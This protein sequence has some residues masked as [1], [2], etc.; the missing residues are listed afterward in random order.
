MP[1]PI[2]TDTPDNQRGLFNPQALL[3]EVSTGAANITVGVPTNA[4]TIWVS[5]TGFPSTPTAKCQGVQTGI[6]Y[7]GVRVPSQGNITANP[8]WVFDVSSAVDQDVTI[9]FSVAP[10]PSW[11]VYADAAPRIVT[12]LT[13][14]VNQQGL[15]YVIPSAPNTNPGDHPPNELQL[16]SGNMT[17]SGVLLGA[18]GANL[19]YRIFALQM[20]GNN[21]GSLGSINN[22]NG[23]PGLCTVLGPVSATVTLPLTGYAL[24]TNTP[25]WANVPAFG[26]Y[27]SAYYTTE[28]V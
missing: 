15:Q 20:M 10:A 28:N 22:G 24:S 18:P 17:A 11:Y 4:E 23:G 21:N 16:G 7:V 27:W 3:A 2:A 9:T 13:K 6:E 19:R 12:D 5:A 26:F 25:L 1:V 14:Y 8:F